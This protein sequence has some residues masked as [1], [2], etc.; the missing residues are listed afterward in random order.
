MSRTYDTLLRLQR[1]QLNEERRRLASLY[2]HQDQLNAATAELEELRRDEAS[3]ANGRE[4]ALRTYPDYARR[5]RRDQAKLADGLAEV[6]GQI[7]LKQDDVGQAYL[8]LKQIEI[9]RD[10]RLAAERAR[11]E[12]IEQARLDEVGLDIHRRRG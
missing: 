7:A 5:V 10:K 9:V 11:L 4:G 8:A 6:S 1:W 12:R 2:D 3:V